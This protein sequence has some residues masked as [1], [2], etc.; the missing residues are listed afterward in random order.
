VKLKEEFAAKMLRVNN[1]VPWEW[2]EHEPESLNDVTHL[3]G[4]VFV[5]KNTAAAP[6]AS[7]VKSFCGMMCIDPGFY[8][9]RAAFNVGTGKTYLLSPRLGGLLSLLIK[10][11]KKAQAQRDV[12]VN[13][14]GIGVRQAK[15]SWLLAK[16][17]R[18]LN[19]N[20]SKSEKR[21]LF[22]QVDTAKKE[23][24]RIL[25]LRHRE[26]PLTKRMNDLDMD[27]EHEVKKSRE[28]TTFF[29]SQF[30]HV[31]EPNFSAS[32]GMVKKG[33]KNGLSKYWKNKGQRMGHAQ[34]RDALIRRMSRK[35]G[36]FNMPSESFSTQYCSCGTLSSPGMFIY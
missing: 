11:K 24:D 12:R 32:K 28:A 16:R 31:M 22:A 1:A 8:F 34:T 13:N 17:D 14:H 23:Y 33:K 21:R 18:A 6:T 2:S 3:K 7:W 5:I 36:C 19:L 15:Q 25:M 27:M 30:S 20:A 4:H 10:L 9:P 26:H 35:G 29:L